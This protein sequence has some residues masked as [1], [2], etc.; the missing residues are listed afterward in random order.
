MNYLRDV[1]IPYD[2]A[3]FDFVIA[4]HMLYHVPDRDRALGEIRRV[5]RPGGTLYAA[6]NGHAHLRELDE[7]AAGVGCDHEMILSAVKFGLET[8]AAQLQRFFTY[9][10]VSRYEDALVVTEPEPLMVYIAS[11]STAA[12]FDDAT[13]ATL[14]AQIESVIATEGAFRITKDAGLLTAHRA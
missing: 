13:L 14:R 8:G 9:V 10:Q 3:S 12:S 2:D 7:L 1:Q 5:L 11:M 6:T 4:N